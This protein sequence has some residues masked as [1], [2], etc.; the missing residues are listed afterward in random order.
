MLITTL[1]VDVIISTT[2]GSPPQSNSS[3]RTF[4]CQRLSACVCISVHRYTRAICLQNVP[5]EGLHTIVLRNVGTLHLPTT[6]IKNVPLTIKSADF[7]T[8]SFGSGIY[9][10]LSRV[11]IS[12]S[13]LDAVVAWFYVPLSLLDLNVS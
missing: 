9:Q 13:K 5:W 11:S 3:E 8:H 10:G 6:F 4:T 1:L 2:M 12:D 7:S